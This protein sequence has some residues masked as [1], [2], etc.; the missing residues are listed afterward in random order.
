VRRHIPPTSPLVAASADEGGVG[1]MGTGSSPLS[2]RRKTAECVT[3]FADGCAFVPIGGTLA[4]DGSRE[5]TYPCTSCATRFALRCTLRMFRSSS[6]SL[7]SGEESSLAMRS[8][9]LGIVAPI[10]PERARS[11]SSPRTLDAA[12]VREVNDTSTIFFIVQV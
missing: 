9:S 5:G 8:Q 6:A 12:R 3:A 2:A 1:G 4:R 7:L 11:S 10:F